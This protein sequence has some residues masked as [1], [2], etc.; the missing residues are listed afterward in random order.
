MITLKPDAKMS[1]LMPHQNKA[2]SLALQQATP[3]QLELL[4]EGK[5]LKSIVSSLFQSKISNT[6]SD[7]VLLDI[8]KNNNAFKQ[9]GNFT[10]ELK[11]VVTTLKAEPN[12]PPN[13][14]V[15]L[16]KLE[17][18]LQ[19]ITTLNAPVLKEKVA[20]SGIFMESKIASAIQ[21]MPLIR[22]TLQNLQ[23][24]L[25]QTPH[26][27]TKNIAQSLAE[28]LEHPVLT[29]AGEDMG[30]ARVLIK[31]VQTLTD[32]IERILP[33]IDPQTPSEAKA[34]EEVR[35][36]IKQL[37]PFTNPE[38]LLI[39]TQLEEHLSNDVKSQLLKLG[40]EI[41]TLAT[42]PSNDVQTQIDKL[43][44]HID[45]H[46][47]LS[48]LDASNTLYFP[49]S[50]DMLEEGSLSFKKRE[51]KKFYCE[52]HLQ[53]KEYGKIDL[54]MALYEGNQLEI[55]AH[56][57]NSQFKDLIKE[58]LSTLRTLLTQAGINPRAIRVYDATESQ[59]P[60]TT[61]Y[62]PEDTD[63]ESGFEVMA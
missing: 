56:T 54:M 4:K 11:N 57:E 39:Q 1:I 23:H 50:W 34:V 17:S 19:S 28:F 51:E 43:I 55:Q 60:S 6:K 63:F 5:D 35:T 9:F 52:V 45:Y 31:S 26:S 36:T 46:Q 2:L 24:A 38:K 62:T 53:L 49:F 41:K 3:G 7:Q 12:L 20:N 21:T 33:K 25:A 61:A 14:A 13:L 10:Q 22:E 16:S 30:S 47:L 44:T 8:L 42:P 15:K 18:S 59:A 27:E 40:E 58:H 29:K 48:H 37:T 32:A